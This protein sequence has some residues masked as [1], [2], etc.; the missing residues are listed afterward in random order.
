MENSTTHPGH[1]AAQM[2]QGLTGPSPAPRPGPFGQ[3][4]PAGSAQHVHGAR[5]LRVGA[6]RAAGVETL[7][8]VK[9]R[10]KPGAS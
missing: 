8:P 5:S 7:P 2:L 10:R 6:A 1:A 9:H 3:P 4:I